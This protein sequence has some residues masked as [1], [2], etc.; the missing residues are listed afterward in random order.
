MT[1]ILVGDHALSDRLLVLKIWGV[2][3]SLIG[4]GRRPSLLDGEQATGTRLRNRTVLHPQDFSNEQIKTY[5]LFV[6]IEY[7]P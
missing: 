2:K 1:T 7:H 6:C 3:D 5:V 4:S